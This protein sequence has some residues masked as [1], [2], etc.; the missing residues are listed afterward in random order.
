MPGHLFLS[1]VFL[2]FP[3]PTFPSLRQSRISSGVVHK[4]RTCDGL[5]WIPSRTTD[6]GEQVVDKPGAG[7]DT[8]DPRRKVAQKLDWKLGQP[9]CYIASDELQDLPQHSPS[10]V[11][12]RSRRRIQPVQHF[13]A[14][15]RAI[16]TPDIAGGAYEIGNCDDEGTQKCCATR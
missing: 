8:I 2:F 4:K 14:Q 1:F 3:F 10:L 16:T 6:S 7:G 13:V 9:V 15:L 12:T 5:R 11:A